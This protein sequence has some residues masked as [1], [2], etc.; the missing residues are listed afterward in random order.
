[1]KKRSRGEGGLASTPRDPPRRERTA[2]SGTEGERVGPTRAAPDDAAIECRTA[3][4]KLHG[5]PLVVESNRGPVVGRLVV[6]LPGLCVFP[7][8]VHR[9]V[10]R[11]EPVG[12]ED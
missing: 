1:M 8:V 2:E 10:R 7:Q 11:R 4:P 9:L 12:R 6:E 5:R 3:D